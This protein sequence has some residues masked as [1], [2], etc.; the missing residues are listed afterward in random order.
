[1][2]KDTNSAIQQRIDEYSVKY[3]DE[4]DAVLKNSGSNVIQV[5]ANINQAQ[6]LINF[7]NHLAKVAS[8]IHLLEDSFL[9]ERYESYPDDS[10]QVKI[11]EWFISAGLHVD[12]REDHTFLEFLQ[13]L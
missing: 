9:G 12:E 2:G 6:E 7:N 10:N 13:V 1:M 8:Y 3:L 11:Q 5:P 4:H